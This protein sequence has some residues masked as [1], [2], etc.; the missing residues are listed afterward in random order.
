MHACEHVY[1]YTNILSTY[2][3][4]YLYLSIF[5]YI[6]IYIYI[7]TYI[8][9]HI[10]IYICICADLIDF[11]GCRSDPALLLQCPQQQNQPCRAYTKLFGLGLGLD[12]SAPQPLVLDVKFA[13]NRVWL[14]WL[15][16]YVNETEKKMTSG[17]CALNPQTGNRKP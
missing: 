14:F 10:Y 13:E 16:L 17:T 1:L 2:L 5:T 8:R 6:D 15:Q 9:V 12:S 11:A 3:P 7:Y 4:T